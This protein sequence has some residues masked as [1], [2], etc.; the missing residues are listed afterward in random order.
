MHCGVVCDIFFCCVEMETEK[1]ED[2]LVLLEE[3]TNKAS[4][5]KERRKVKKLDR[6]E[7]R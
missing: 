6:K 1:P 4:L 3:L 5:T 2:A 7:R